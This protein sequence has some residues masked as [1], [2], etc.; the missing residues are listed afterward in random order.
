MKQNMKKFE[1]KA[2]PAATFVLFFVMALA[3]AA[4]KQATYQKP[5][6]CVTHKGLTYS[7]VLIKVNLS[8][9]YTMKD[10]QEAQRTRP[11][12]ILNQLNYLNPGKYQLADGVTPNLNLYITL[13]TDSYGHYG[14]TLTGYVHDGDF[15]RSLNTNYVTLEK[16]YDDI[17]TEVNYFVRNGWCNNCPSP[18]NP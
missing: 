1:S 16:L 17:A 2:L 4:P 13:Q 3:S 10:L 12:Y 15:Y 6:P 9:D 11:V 14:A 5:K 18:C 7:P 8:G